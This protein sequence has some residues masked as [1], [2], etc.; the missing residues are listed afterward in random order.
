MA[1]RRPLE[2]RG[3]IDDTAAYYQRHTSWRW[4]AGVGHAGDGRELA[5]NLVAGVNDPP[6]DSERT[7]WVAGQP[8]EAGPVA[9]A[10]DLSAVGD[11]RF[12]S[13]AV[14]AANTNLLIVRSAYRQP[15]GTFSGVLPGGVRVA[16]GY[17]VMEYHD[18]RW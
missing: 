4:S 5:W 18:A 17:G 3:L 7:V 1:A 16:E 2:A 13:E 15:F 11:L 8:S 6:T 12:A 9:F 10:A 14:R